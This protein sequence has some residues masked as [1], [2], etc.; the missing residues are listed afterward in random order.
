LKVLLT[1][2]GIIRDE[3]GGQESLH[4]G[5]CLGAKRGDDEGAEECFRVKV[6]GNAQHAHARTAGTRADLADVTRSAVDADR[7]KP[8]QMRHWAAAETYGP[9]K[10]RIRYQRWVSRRNLPLSQEP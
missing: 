5:R 8:A 2:G 3:V 6:A 9:A 7:R 10:I 4:V 1:A